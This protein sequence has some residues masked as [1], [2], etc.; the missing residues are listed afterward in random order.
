MA[1]S[2]CRFTSNGAVTRS[3]F[4]EKMPI[5]IQALLN[6]TGA[7]AANIMKGI[8]KKHDATGELT[9]SIMWT[10]TTGGSHPQGW[11]SNTKEIEKPTDAYEVRAGS[12]AEHAVYR[13]TESGIH[14]T[15]DGSELF[16]S[17]MKDWYW[18]KFKKNPDVHENYASFRGM[19]AKI[20][21]TK[22]SGVP[23]VKP[24]KEIIVPYMIKRF[25]RVIKQ[26]LQTKK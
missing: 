3:A 2:R 1:S 24:T 4:A 18:I 17:R 6:D 5:M 21:Y 12:A 7:Y 13:E 26:A 23:F 15:D 11:A 8:T 10:S 19:P 9:D 20:R 16:V 25:A 14:L 22:T